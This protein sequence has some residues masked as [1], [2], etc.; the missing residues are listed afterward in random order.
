MDS[1]SQ[2]FFFNSVSFSGRDSVYQEEKRAVQTGH[3]LQNELQGVNN[4][5][6][7]GTCLFRIASCATP[8]AAVCQA[9]LFMNSPGKKTGAGCHSLLQGIFPTQGSSP[10]LPHCSQILYHLSHQGSPFRIRELIFT[11]QHSKIKCNIQFSIV[12]QSFFFFSG[13]EI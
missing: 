3:S 5:I 4:D 13:L 1:R 9:F 11:L 8:W 7:S 12:H 6:K 2:L 10:G